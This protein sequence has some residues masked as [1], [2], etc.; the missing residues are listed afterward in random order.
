MGNHR[1]SYRW[2]LKDTI[3]TKDKGKV[4]SCFAGGGGS[5]MGYK[6]AGFD[7][8]GCNEID[9]RMNNVYVANHHPKLN[10]LSPIQEFKL[11]MDLPREL[12]N[13]DILDGSPPCSSF[14][15]A[16]NRDNDWGKE[17]KFRE[18][19]SSQVLD[20][21]FFFFFYLAKLLRPKVV[22]AENVKGLLI[23]N[24]IDYVRRIYEAFN[25]SGY[26]VCH[27]LCDASKMGVPQ[28]R[29]R[30][31][32]TA[33]REDLFQY[34]PQ[35]Q[36]LFESYPYLDLCFNEDEIK[37][38]EFSDCDG[39]EIK[40]KMYDWWLKR[41]QGDTC[42]GD[43]VQREEERNAFFSQSYIYKDKVVPT[44]TGHE[45]S[46]IPFDKPRYT[47]RNEC[48]YI[49]S[50]PL[51]YDFKNE[52]PHYI[53]GMSV[54]PIMMAQVASRIYTQWLSKINENKSI[55]KKTPIQLTLF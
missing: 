35:H 4:F 24:A 25:N 13:L 9:P 51:D 1:F 18:G 46:L 28:R 38:G 52:K 29:E 53:C 6:L 30:V 14:S 49:S 21:L 43:A 44:L 33:I 3:F 50:F 11:Q 10:Y 45:D 26:K 16:G 17:K 27:N 12:Y 15:T 22:V 37:Y 34:V 47:S 40:G 32:F 5:T 42:M 55:V 48:C 8:I 20:T 54:P 19:Q 23:G 31:F 41:K 2:S 36:D 39:R 7:V